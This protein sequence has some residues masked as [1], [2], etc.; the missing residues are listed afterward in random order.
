MTNILRNLNNTQKIT[1]INLFMRSQKYLILLIFI[2][3]YSSVKSATVTFTGTSGGSWGTA[4]NWSTNSLPGLSDSVVIPNAKSVTMNV[5]ASITS[6]NMGTGSTAT[7]LT[8]NSGVTLT[9]SNVLNFSAVSNTVSHTIAIGSGT[10]SCKNLIM[11]NNNGNSRVSSITISTGKL[12]VSRNITFNG[13]RN[14]ENQIVFSGAGTLLI[15]GDFNPTFQTFTTATGS[16]VV[17]N[18]STAQTIKAG[19][20]FRDLQFYG[21]GVK[22]FSG[23]TTTTVGSAATD[24]LDI[25]AGTTVNVGTMQFA[26]GAASVKFNVSGT[27]QTDNT[28]GLSGT[29]L[30]TFS[31]TNTPVITLVSGSIIEYEATLAQTVTSAVNYQG[32]TITGNSTKTIGSNVTVNE[33]LIINSTAILAHNTTTLTVSGNIS[34]AGTLTTTS[35][36]LNIAGDFNLTG[37]YNC[38]TG[39]VNYTKSGAQVVDGTTYNNLTISGSGAK[40]LAGNASVGATLTLQGL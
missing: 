35:G 9:I 31:S 14:I 40:T 22:T 15:G 5:S 6:L 7:T 3:I 34:G 21:T 30:T 39:T 20:T 36:T 23:T 16:K 19:L 1:Q 26:A 11:A 13:S 32:L 18:G 17:F 28:N 12:T 10:V 37:V 27:L 38:G 4:S 8:I 2:F 24:S 25:R 33:G 29:T